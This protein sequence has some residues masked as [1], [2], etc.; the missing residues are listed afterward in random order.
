M[1]TD[2]SGCEPRESEGR[3]T[4]KN[5]SLDLAN[6]FGCRVHVNTFADDVLLN[7][8]KRFTKY[9]QKKPNPKNKCLNFLPARGTF[10]YSLLMSTDDALHFTVRPLGKPETNVSV[11]TP[12]YCT[13]TVLQRYFFYTSLVFFF[14]FFLNYRLEFCTRCF[15]VTATTGPRCQSLS[16]TWKHPVCVHC[17]KKCIFI[18]K[19]CLLLNQSCSDSRFCLFTVKIF[20]KTKTQKEA[21]VQLLHS[22]WAHQLTTGQHFTFILTQFQFSSVPSRNSMV[23]FGKSPWI[24]AELHLLSPAS[25]FIY[26]FVS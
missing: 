5:T 3:F 4:W 23:L 10:Q 16:W 12:W 1:S 15:L 25:H 2:H 7:K 19:W 9:S 21:W 26:F 18:T 20:F 6:G 11:F 17:M 8:L 13:A 14:F 24:S 22:F